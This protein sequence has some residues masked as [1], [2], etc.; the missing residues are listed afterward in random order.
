MQARSDQLP[1]QGLAENAKRLNVAPV[2]SVNKS[3]GMNTN[4]AGAL[5]ADE[6][7][8]YEQLSYD[9][10]RS[11]IGAPKLSYKVVAES[12][13]QYNVNVR[14]TWDDQPS[15]AVRVTLNIDAGGARAY[16][17]MT[18]DFIKQPFSD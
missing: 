1:P 16:F 6:T 7:A 10:L 17:P 5:L 11:M 14:A 2:V 13:V 9:R 18:A 4:E 8:K 15:G 3:L 12:G